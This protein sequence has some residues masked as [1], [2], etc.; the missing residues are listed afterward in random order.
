MSWGQTGVLDTE[1]P[2]T[3]DMISG[4][5]VWAAGTT[6]ADGRLEMAEPLNLGFHRTLEQGTLVNPQQGWV[7]VTA[8][9]FSPWE[10]TTH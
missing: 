9:V 6:T 3:I 1:S 2:G 8:T 5:R 4:H 7:V 10:V